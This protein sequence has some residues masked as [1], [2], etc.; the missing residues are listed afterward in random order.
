MSKLRS[1][2]KGMN[3]VENPDSGL[4]NNQIEDTAR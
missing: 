3:R 1:H 2:G 4:T